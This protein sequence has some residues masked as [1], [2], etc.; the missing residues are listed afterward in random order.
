[1]TMREL[2]K[3]RLAGRKPR[4]SIFL[5]LTPVVHEHIPDQ[6]VTAE[7][8]DDFAVLTDLSVI[9]CC[10]SAQG[11]LALEFIDRALPEDPYNLIF[12]VIDRGVAVN[13]VE[14]GI[15]TNTRTVPNEGWR[16]TIEVLKCSS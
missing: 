3:H 16:E 4:Q 13:I 11:D 15:R 7:L 8:S 10:N 6:V 5:A 14:H 12:W 9:V 1:M 2:E